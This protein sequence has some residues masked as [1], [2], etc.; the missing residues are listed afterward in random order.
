[1]QLQLHIAIDNGILTASFSP[2]LNRPYLR[3]ILF[4]TRMS[5]HGTNRAQIN[6][7]FGVETAC[8]LGYSL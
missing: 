6:V 2:P 1:M 4:K 7:A 5:F 8:N 3:R